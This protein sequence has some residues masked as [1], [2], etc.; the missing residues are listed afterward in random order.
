MHDMLGF[1]D[2]VPKFAKKYANLGPQ[3]LEAFNEY[4]KEV[5]EGLF[6]TPEYSYN[7]KVEGLE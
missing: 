5:A 4:H 2:W 7:T 6:P 3:M 1:Y